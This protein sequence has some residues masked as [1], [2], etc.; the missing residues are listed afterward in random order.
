M[1]DGLKDSQRDAI[2]GILKKCPKLERARLFGSRAMGTHTPTSDVDIAL[3]GDLS[4][5]DQTNLSEK[6]ERLTIPYKVDLVRVKEISS[7][8]LKEHIKKYGVVW[9]A[10]GEHGKED[11]TTNEHELT[12]MVGKTRAAGGVS[13]SASIQLGSVADMVTDKVSTKSLNSTNYIS[14]ENML[15]NRGGIAAP[16]NIPDQRATLFKEEDTLFS[17]I[18]TYFRKV[19]LADRKGG[20]SPDV[21]V[22]RSRDTNLCDSKFLHYLI[23]SEHFIDYTVLTAKGAK[24]PRGDKEAMN[25]F[26]FPEICIDEQREIGRILKTLDDKIALNRKLNETLEGMARALFQSWFVDFDPV[27]AKCAAQKVL[28]SRHIPSPQTPGPEGEGFIDGEH[29]YVTQACMAALSGKLRIPP[30]KPKPETLAE[31]SVASAKVDEQLPSAK[32][33]DEAIA[34]LPSTAGRG[35]EGEGLCELAKLFPSDFQESELG[36]IPEGWEVAT[37]DSFIELAYGKALKKTDRKE[38]NVPVYGSGGV[39]GYHDKALVS[40]PGIIVGRKGTV[41]SLYWEPDCFYPIDTVFYVK[42]NREVSL[43]YIYYLLE[44]LGLDGMNTDA[45]V[46]GLNR[47]NVYRLLVPCFPRGLVEEF[48]RHVGK[49]RCSLDS[50]LNQSR[51]L[52]ELRDTLLPKLLSGELKTN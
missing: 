1:N 41:G 23:S 33:I 32:E 29:P 38:G 11:G 43:V 36:L 12:R 30:G 51:T 8:E 46:P 3:D 15:P 4:L 13:E 50:N 9:Y 19:W 2:I 28:A 27:K 49:I 17:N 14:T 52:A 22:F 25:L 21:I 47:N 26:E 10:R 5:T 6:L 35:T 48:S 40:G 34:Q 44:T 7:R 39:N 16:A 45:A 37:L 20:A 18:R 42:P 24:M 31:S